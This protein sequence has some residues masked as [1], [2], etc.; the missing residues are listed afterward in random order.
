VNEEQNTTTPPDSG[1]SDVLT[2]IGVIVAVIGILAGYT[3]DHGVI[4]ALINIP[5]FCFTIIGAMGATAASS[6]MEVFKKFPKFIMLA[7]KPPAAIPNEAIVQRLV[8]FADKA[9]KSGLLA[10]EQEV[11]Q[12]PI[13][14]LQKGM[15]LII[16][17]TAADKVRDTLEIEV[18][19][20]K[21]R[22]AEN[23]Q[24][25]LS[26]A[27]FSPTFGILGTVMGLISVLGKLSDPASLGPSIATAFIAT[28]YGVGSANIFFFPVANKLK[29]MSAQEAAQRDIIVEGVLSIQAGELPRDLEDKLRSFLPP[30]AVAAAAEPQPAPAGQSAF[31]ADE[32][33]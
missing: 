11:K 26:W 20:M 14:F 4:G 27:G 15:Q 32:D 12:V 18:D 23:A 25:F 19:A 8:E 10:L 31:T 3:I 6:K 17:G 16:D 30:E 29:A 9:R 13:P 7:L 5:A 33:E 24:I 21:R 1:K 2:L 22:H 28:L